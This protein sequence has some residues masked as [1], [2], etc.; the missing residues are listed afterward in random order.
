MPNCPNKR[1]PFRY[2][3]LTPLLASAPF[4]VKR[5]SKVA[6]SESSFCN[7]NFELENR[8]KESFAA[9]SQNAQDN[10]Y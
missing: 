2:F 3:F 6:P 9:K 5:V 8:S 4:A 10:N 1:I 7:A